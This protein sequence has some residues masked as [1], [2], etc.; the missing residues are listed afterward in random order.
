MLSRRRRLWH[1]VRRSRPPNT[2]V[3]DEWSAV[4]TIVTPAHVQEI[5]DH[6]HETWDWMPVCTCTS[7]WFEWTLTHDDLSKLLEK[8]DSPSLADA[9]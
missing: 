2:P 8:L 5:M 9:A 4:G 6:L 3:R 1:S 7:H